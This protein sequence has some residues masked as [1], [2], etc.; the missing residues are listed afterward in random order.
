[1]SE[2]QQNSSDRIHNAI[3]QYLE[4]LQRSGIRQLPRLPDMAPSLATRAAGQPAH[5]ASAVSE[6]TS[7]Q[8]VPIATSIDQPIALAHSDNIAAPVS[9]GAMTEPVQTS[10]PSVEPDP[11]AALDRVRREVMHCTLCHE[12]AQTRTQT[13]FGTGNPSARLCFLGEAPGADEDRQGEPFVGAAG[14]LLDKIIQ[15]CTLK[16]EDVY[17]LNVLKCRPPNNRTPLPEETANCRNFFERQLAIIQPEFICC[18]GAVASQTLLRTTQ[19]LGRLRGQWHDYQGIRVMVTYH[20]A[21]L[22]R[23]PDRKRDTWED[24]KMLMHEMGIEL[25]AR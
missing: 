11:L 8:T 15:A 13:V 14:R 6:A 20:P 18:L 10:P 9:Q 24:M 5:A 17:I 22:L 7:T 16:R 12:L 19:S 1:M 2:L 3:R 4:S 25:P 23:A 21:Y